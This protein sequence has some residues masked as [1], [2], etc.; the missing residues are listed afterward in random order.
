MHNSCLCMYV[1]MYVLYVL[2][3]CVCNVCM[4]VQMSMMCLLS[5]IDASIPGVT[6]Y[7]KTSSYGMLSSLLL[8]IT[9]WVSNVV[10]TLQDN[11]RNQSIILYTL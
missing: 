10:A 11:Q 2:H 5:F 9:C 7:G 6:I 1:C 4:Y 3:V 8:L